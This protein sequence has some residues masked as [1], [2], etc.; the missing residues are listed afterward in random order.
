MSTWLV[1]VLT[2]LGVMIG[3]LASFLS[4]KSIERIRWQRDQVVVLAKKRLDCYGEFAAAIKANVAA[5][6]RLVAGSGLPAGALPIEREAGLSMLASARLD[7]Q[8]KWENVQL[9][10][11]PDTISAAQ[12]WRTTVKH[13]EQFARGILTDPDEW[14]EAEKASTQA[15]E[16][17]YSSARSELLIIGGQ[18]T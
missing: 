14:L 7:L 6:H 12:Q 15:R 16:N 1:Q 9:Y 3:A 5:T 18:I 11:A 2:L 4:T 8:V 17:F 13:L 10:G